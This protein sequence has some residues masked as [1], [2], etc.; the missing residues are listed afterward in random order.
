MLK[1]TFETANFGT[2]AALVLGQD[3]LEKRRWEKPYGQASYLVPALKEMVSGAGYAFARVDA[4]VTTLGPGSFTGQRLG[5]CIA[6]TLAFAGGLCVWGVSSFEWMARAYLRAYPENVRPILVCLKTGR[7]DLFCQLFNE[8]GHAVKDPLCLLPSEMESYA[9][10]GILVI[11]QDLER[12]PSHMDT[13]DFT[14]HALDL[15]FIEKPDHTTLA[16]FYLRG[17]EATPSGL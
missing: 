17:V 4:V 9:G 5:L 11:G 15:A 14:P 13:R 16:P 7:P 2:S 3:V 6:Q 8:K 12:V 1:L 10:Q